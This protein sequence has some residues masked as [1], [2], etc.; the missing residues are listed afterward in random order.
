MRLNLNHTEHVQYNKIHQ[1]NIHKRVGTYVCTYTNIFNL[2]LHNRQQF[3]LLQLR[4]QLQI[5]MQWQHA[6]EKADNHE[7]Y[8]CKILGEPFTV[9]ILIKMKVE[10]FCMYTSPSDTLA[11]LLCIKTVTHN[12]SVHILYEVLHVP[13][14]CRSNLTVS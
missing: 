3:R 13:Q 5:A 2:H 10:F 14:V 1:H 12:T 11:R 8:L 9:K 4:F 6:Q 7:N